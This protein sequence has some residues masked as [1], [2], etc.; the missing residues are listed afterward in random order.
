MALYQVEVTGWNSYGESI[1]DSAQ[2]RAASE[3][4]A[5]DS[6]INRMRSMWDLTE[7][8]DCRVHRVAA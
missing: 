4:E 6:L 1:E 3:D 5:M 8:G 2:V 7:V